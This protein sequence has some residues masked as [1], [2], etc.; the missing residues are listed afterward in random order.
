MEEESLLL[1][2]RPSLKKPINAEPPSQSGLFTVRRR[3][4]SG[5]C[6]DLILMALHSNY[7]GFLFVCCALLKLTPLSYFT[8]QLQ[9][10][11]EK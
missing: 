2:R 10:K 5:Q 11:H 7:S 4:C 9:Q 3:S 1:Q 6:L 8:N